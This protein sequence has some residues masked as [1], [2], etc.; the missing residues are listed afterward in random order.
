[1][2]PGAFVVIQLSFHL[3][4]NCV[5]AEL[6]LG[7]EIWLRP[8]RRWKNVLIKVWAQSWAQL[9]VWKP[10]TRMT[11]HGQLHLNDCSEMSYLGAFGCGGK[12]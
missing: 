8:Q 5:M 9:A 12:I 3:A 6:N 1:M 7:I 10:P 11:A 2:L 4:A